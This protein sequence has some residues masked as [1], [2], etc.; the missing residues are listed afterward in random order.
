MSAS[1]A[2]MKPA[3][4]KLASSRL[5]ELQEFVWEG[6]DKRGKV[7][8][9]EQTAKNANMLRAELRRQGISPTMVK[10]KPKPLFGGSAH[11]LQ[12]P[13]GVAACR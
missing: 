12:Y 4:G 1:R 6:R 2:A 10:P 8:K 5:P 13:A 9:G 11:P 3:S 7:M